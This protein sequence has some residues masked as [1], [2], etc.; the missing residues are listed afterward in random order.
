MKK[1]Y[2][3]RLFAELKKA[4]FADHAAVQI[5]EAI[6][7]QDKVYEDDEQLQKN[8]LLMVKKAIQSTLI[9]A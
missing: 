5:S 4:G 2:Y 1:D 9:N 3:N 7:Y 6:L 8:Y